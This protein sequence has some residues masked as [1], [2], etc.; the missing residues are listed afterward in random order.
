MTLRS[1]GWG[2]LPLVLAATI[3]GTNHSCQNSNE[4]GRLVSMFA[5]VVTSCLRPRGGK[6]ESAH[7]LQDA[8][9][10][11]GPSF[12]A[13]PRSSGPTTNGD[14]GATDGGGANKPDP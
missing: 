2:L 3:G 6:M 1:A 13:E 8:P 5:R 9:I 7:P 14:Y 11:S 10:S 12:S 4:E